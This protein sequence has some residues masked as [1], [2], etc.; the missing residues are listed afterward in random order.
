MALINEISSLSS[1]FYDNNFHNMVVSHFPYFKKNN[2]FEQKDIGG[3][4][5]EIYKGDFL[6]LLRHLGMPMEYHRI[7]SEF[8]N[9]CSPLD[10]DGD[11]GSIK[12]INSSELLRLLNVYKTQD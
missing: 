1:F 7:T 6:G 12:I 2:L 10:Y 11:A 4:I 8:N 5:A 9:L 3:S